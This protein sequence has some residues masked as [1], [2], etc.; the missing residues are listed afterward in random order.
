MY[1]LG[2]VPRTPNDAFEALERVFGGDEFSA[3]EAEE[4]LEEVLELSPDG[5]RNEFRALLRSRAVEE[6]S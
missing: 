4:V 2:E 3:R 6:E 5:A 1:V